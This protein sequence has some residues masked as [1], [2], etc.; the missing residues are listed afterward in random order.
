MLLTLNAT[1]LRSMLEAKRSGKVAL[2][3]PDL[4]TF[5][6]ETLG[7]HG[8]NMSTSQLSGIDRSG[9]ETLR[10]RADKSGCACLLLIEADAQPLGDPSEDRANAALDRLRLVLQAAQI[11]GCSAIAVSPSGADSDETVQKTAERLRKL[12][13]TA[14]RA[15]IN[16]LLS[17]G[18]GVS[19]TPER[20]TE[21][22]KKVG[23][24]RV[25]TFPDFQAAAASPDP[26]P[27]LRRLTPYATVVSAATVQF[28]APGGGTPG[29][30]PDAPVEHKPYDLRP[31]VEAVDAVGFDGT[32]AVDYR[33]KGD[34]VLGI[35]RSRR[36]LESILGGDVVDEDLE[37]DL[38]DVEEEP[39]AEPEGEDEKP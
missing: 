18:K 19:S 12:M 34:P 6:R 13:H 33:G 37:A 3:L 29:D 24:F 16:I 39:A 14:E 20:V 36:M 26:V 8:L 31:L 11:L 30:A 27:Y 1:S 28:V 15:E 5:T 23:G 35:L 10:D 2:K 4:P 32:L 7:L 9:L 22:I 21:I 38:L 17:P 25:G